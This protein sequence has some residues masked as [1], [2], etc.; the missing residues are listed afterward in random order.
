MSDGELD[1]VFLLNK[2]LKMNSAGRFITKQNGVK[3]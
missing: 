3:D 2:K 1:I